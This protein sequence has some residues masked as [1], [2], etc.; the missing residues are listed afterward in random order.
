MLE[1]VQTLFVRK[2]DVVEIDYAFH[3]A[4]FDAFG[5]VGNGL[6]RVDGLKNTF[7]VCRNLR[8]ILHDGGQ[9]RQRGRKQAH[10]T[11][12]RDHDAR[13]YAH[14]LR[15]HQQECDRIQQDRAEIPKQSDDRGVE[16]VAADNAHPCVGAVLLQIVVHLFVIRR[17]VIV[18]N[19]FFAHDRL[20]DKGRTVGILRALAAEQFADRLADQ[21]HA[22]RQRHDH[23]IYDQ[24]KHGTERKHEHRHDENLDDIQNK[25]HQVVGE[26]VCKFR[27]IVCDADGDL[28]R[29]TVIEIVEG[30][31][32][33]L[34]EDIPAD[35]RNDA[36]PRL[37]HLFLL[38]I[39]DDDFGE[40]ADKEPAEHQQE[41]AVPAV[42]AMFWNDHVDDVLQQH[43]RQ[44]GKYD[45]HQHQNKHEHKQFFVRRGIAKQ[46][47]QIFYVDL[48]L[49][50]DFILKICIAL[51]HVKPPRRTA[52][53]MPQHLPGRPVLPS[54]CD[55]SRQRSRSFAS[56]R[57]TCRAR[58]SRRPAST[59]SRR[60]P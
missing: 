3:V 56:V 18:L 46:A 51:C 29:R 41:I 47:A 7:Q 13:R 39:S 20:D 26:K 60:N 55:R 2:S 32:L 36:V 19:N 37:S 59:G 44:H 10:I 30:E 4:Q 15:I 14:L 58:R 45:R 23:H 35:I 52:H 57:R 17:A 28:A 54:A 11:Q 22:Y 6:G 5:A 42:F 53:S 25:V 50:D 33:Q 38:K 27:D 43:R 9:L 31:R 21:E 16:F 8:Q 48:F 12:K 1:N 40:S 49:F 34:I 24:R